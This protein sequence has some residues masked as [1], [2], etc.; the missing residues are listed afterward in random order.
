MK[1]GGSAP[2]IYVEALIHCDMEDLWAKT[3]EPQLHQRWDLRFTGITYLEKGE[4][5]KAQRF[6]YTRSFGPITIKGIGETVGERRRSDGSATS[7][8][9]FWS[10]DPRSLIREGSG[11]WRYVPTDAGIRFLTRYDYNVRFGAIGRWVDRLL[12]RPLMG[13]A[14]A[15]SFDALRMWLERDIPPEYSRRAAVIREASRISLAATWLYH[16]LI[17]KLLFRDSGEKDLMSGIGL[18]KGREPEALTAAGL[19]EVGFGIT[20]AARPRSRWPFLVNLFA[21]PLATLGAWRGNRK[22]FT[23]PFGP[24]TLNLVMMALAVAG[25][26]STAE[27]PTATN[28]LREA[29][30]ME[31]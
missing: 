7:A 27:T 12:W 8:L 6:E 2:P 9:R 21:L 29:N 26:L 14:T 16:G 23:E 17:P 30:Q 20:M 11:Y 25:L 1:L 28:C 4:R 5:D 13:W 22:I 19:G 24:A 3:Q 10:D 18:L 31:P 15:W